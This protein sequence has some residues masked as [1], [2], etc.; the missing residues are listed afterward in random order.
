MEDLASIITSGTTPSFHPLVPR[1]VFPLSLWIT[2]KPR[3]LPS[4]FP[5]TLASVSQDASRQNQHLRLRIS[6][7]QNKWSYF[8]QGAGSKTQVKSLIT[9]F[10]SLAAS[11]FL[12]MHGFGVESWNWLLLVL[13]VEPLK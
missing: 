4:L 10:R 8:N 5:Y 6:Q 11:D 7:P 2:T 1:I 3:M 13:N 9:R 12:R